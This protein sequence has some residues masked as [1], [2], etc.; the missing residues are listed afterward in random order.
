MLP[1]HLPERESVDR[2]EQ[3]AGAAIWI[4]G[5]VFLAEGTA[6]A[7]ALKQNVPG[8]GGQ[9]VWNRVCEGEK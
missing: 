8:V 4:L 5:R 7:K 9:C 2:L 3:R 6:S 1:A